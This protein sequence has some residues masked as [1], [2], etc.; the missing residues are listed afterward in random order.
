MAWIDSG[1]AVVEGPG[2]RIDRARSAQPVSEWYEWVDTDDALAEVVEA[3]RGIADRY[4]VDT[5]FHRERTYYP[6]VALIQWAWDDR[7]ALIDPL[8]VNVAPL[9]KVLDGPGLAVMHAAGQDL[10]VLELACGTIPTRLID[11]QIAAGF[12]GHTT[13]SLATLAERELGIR[14]PKGDRLT[15]WLRRPLDSDQKS[16]AADDVAYLF[17]ILDRLVAALTRD[18]RLGWAEAECEEL[19]TKSRS[20]RD[21]DEA[22]LRIKEARHLKGAPAGVAQA[23]AAWRE[24]RAAAIDQPVRFILSDLGV[25]G[26]AQ[27]LPTSAAQLKGIRGLDDRHLRGKVVDELLEVVAEGR[28]QVAERPRTDALVE[29]E[30]QLRPAVTLVSAWLSQLAREERIETSLLGTRADIEALLGKLEG[31]RLAEG[32]RAEMVGEPIKRLVA[33]QAAL[34][35]STG[36]GWPRPRR[37]QRHPHRLTPRSRL[38]PPTVGAGDAPPDHRSRADRGWVDCFSRRRGRGRLLRRA[39]G[40]PTVRRGRRS[41]L[42][43]LTATVPGAANG[44]SRGRVKFTA[45]T[46]RSPGRDPGPGQHALGPVEPFEPTDR[47]VPRDALRTASMRR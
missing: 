7:I 37:A 18:G 19:R 27:R 32:W 46:Q 21:P 31:A 4:A 34:A 5:E 17:P 6:Q 41:A 11:T 25:V 24:R 10:E 30:R 15:D 26:V 39:A 28:T 40:S 13:P 47:R 2:A 42:T 36:P 38:T 16:Y 44:T 3:R 35:S 12:E 1:R 23:V 43:L 9:A 29:I 45:I 14:L 33:G 20:L 22:W 8:A